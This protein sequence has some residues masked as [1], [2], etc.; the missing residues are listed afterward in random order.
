MDF[1][2]ND[3]VWVRL[4]PHGR[5]MLKANHAEICAAFPNILADLAYTPPVEDLDGWSEWQMWGLMQEFG[6]HTGNGK[7][8]CFEQNVI[9][10]EDQKP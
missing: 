7:P 9:R 5:A 3:T 4:T 1:N 10:I 6:E 2:I 8:Q